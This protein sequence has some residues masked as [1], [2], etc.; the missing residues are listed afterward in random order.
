MT[1]QALLER[2]EKADWPQDMVLYSP[3]VDEA[4]R[5]LGFEKDSDDAWCFHLALQGSLDAAVA[6]VEKMLPGWAWGVHVNLRAVGGFLAHVTE[7]SP[8]RPMPNIGAAPTP[9][10][11]LIAAL[12]RA[13]IAQQEKA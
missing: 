9:A 1:L 2:V 10:L 3:F 8:I 13:L 5:T 11:A 7:R 4:A 12:L 6:L